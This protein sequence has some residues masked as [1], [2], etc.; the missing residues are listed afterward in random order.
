MPPLRQNAACRGGH[1]MESDVVTNAS[2][3]ERNW[4]VL[5]H[6]SGLL[7]VTFIG[8]L[9]PAFVIWL[10]RRDED[11]FASQQAREALNF[12]VTLFLL[13]VVSAILFIVGVGVV[14]YFVFYVLGLVLSVVGAVRVSEGIAY[15]YPVNLRLVS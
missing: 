3:E 2:K 1:I 4:A 11:N 13:L 14:L 12:Q 7:A 10:L 9:I 15:R 6:L 5:A 8:G